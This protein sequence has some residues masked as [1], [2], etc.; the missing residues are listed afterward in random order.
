MPSFLRPNAERCRDFLSH[1][2][3][4]VVHIPTGD[5]LYFTLPFDLSSLHPMRPQELEALYDFL[6]TIQDEVAERLGNYAV[7][8]VLR[9]QSIILR[10]LK[11]A[12][13]L[14]DLETQGWAT[15]LGF[16]VFDEF[17]Y[18][19]NFHWDW[20][21]IEFEGLCSKYFELVHPAGTGYDF[22]TIYRTPLR[23][24]SP[25]PNNSFS[26]SRYGSANR[27]RFRSESGKTSITHGATFGNTHEIS[28]FLNSFSDLDLALPQ[29]RT[30][31]LEGDSHRGIRRIWGPNA[32][33][34][35]ERVSQASGVD[36]ETIEPTKVHKRNLQ[37]KT[38]PK[39]HFSESLHS[40]ED[41]YQRGLISYG[42]AAETNSLVPSTDLYLLK[43]YKAMRD[44]GSS[45]RD[46][47]EEV[48]CVKSID[49]SSLPERSVWDDHPRWGEERYTYTFPN[50]P[51][52]CTSQ[53][54]LEQAMPNRCPE[55]LTEERYVLPGSLMEQ[56]KN[57]GQDSERR[58][59]VVQPPSHREVDRTT[60][61]SHADPQHVY[62]IQAQ[63]VHG[64]AAIVHERDSFLSSGR[65]RGRMAQVK[66]AKKLSKSKNKERNRIPKILNPLEE[67]SAALEC[68]E[69]EQDAFQHIAQQGTHFRDHEQQTS[70]AQEVI[71]QH[72]HDPQIICNLASDP[73]RTIDVNPKTYRTVLFQ[74]PTRL[75]IR[76]RA[77][78]ARPSSYHAGLNDS[79]RPKSHRPSHQAYAEDSPED[80]PRAGF[81]SWR[82]V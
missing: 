52:Y 66:A 45:E 73:Q 18:P 54:I 40:Y 1:P 50:E 63:P 29:D 64:Q 60:F 16:P 48:A 10:W 8:N 19:V 11:N 39:G 33:L 27:D 25:P 53:V 49:P 76:P 6:D 12:R 57:P 13:Y 51:K 21:I 42:L 22:H 17:Q 28:G 9:T 56:G 36:M 72:E 70:S 32:D 2:D 43:L 79:G 59:R 35:P 37:I 69:A 71:I 41:F 74:E 46:A 24:A 20:D 4:Y 82:D 65:E 80:S 47:M 67:M 30:I 62:R 55:D 78:A 14:G 77:A 26:R 44:Q 23:Y 61:T 81:S 5:D 34:Y 7:E 58:V 3:A 38:K 68:G 31:Q 75:F 15:G